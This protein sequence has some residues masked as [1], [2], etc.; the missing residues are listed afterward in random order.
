GM[1]GGGGNGRRQRRHRRGLTGAPSGDNLHLDDRL[2]ALALALGELLEDDALVVGQSLAHGRD[3]QH[4]PGQPTV[5]RE[6]VS[7]QR[8]IAK[9]LA[10]WRDWLHGVAALSLAVCSRDAATLG[11]EISRA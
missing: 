1:V 11:G 2:A 10:Q 4:A 9:G 7:E 8:R 3:Q 5:A 6:N